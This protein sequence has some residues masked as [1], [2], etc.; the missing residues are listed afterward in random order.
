MYHTAELIRLEEGPHGTF[1]ILKISKRIFCATLEPRDMLNKKNI[2]NIPAP[3][4]YIC[5][6]RD[7]R[8]GLTFEV[9]NVP[10]R[11]G[12]LFH[13]GNYVG[14]TE[15]CILLG[16]YVG[17]LRGERAIHN[18]GSTFLRFMERMKY[19]EEFLLT[20]DYKL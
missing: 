6:L 16:Q 11:T 4:Q 19:V 7:S 2:S 1:G 15:G 13:A 10:N 12:I 20:I 14:D 17:K 18:S 9:M 5:Q 8:F 3:Q